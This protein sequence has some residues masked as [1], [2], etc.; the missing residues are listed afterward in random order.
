MLFSCCFP[1]AASMDS[2]AFFHQL[3]LLCNNPLLQLLPCLVCL[4]HGLPVLIAV[5]W[6]MLRWVR[7]LLLKRPFLIRHS[8]SC[9]G[10]VGSTS[11]RVSAE[12]YDS[13][14]SRIRLSNEREGGSFVAVWI[15]KSGRRAGRVEP[16]TG[17]ENP[18]RRSFLLVSLV[19][20]LPD[21]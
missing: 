20:L 10:W 17:L 2:Y 19:I 1:L 4:H 16:S 5:K 13:K 7:I 21:H 6:C 11:H 3:D 12:P 15:P 14:K 18:N 8:L 9:G